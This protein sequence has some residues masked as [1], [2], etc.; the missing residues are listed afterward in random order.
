MRKK[1][2]LLFSLLVSS[3]WGQQLAQTYLVFKEGDS[4]AINRISLEEIPGEKTK[5]VSIVGYVEKPGL[6]FLAVENILI[7][8]LMKIAGTI[9]TN[10]GGRSSS[11]IQIFK[12]G[13]TY[14]VSLDH[15]I[16]IDDE[17]KANVSHLSVTGG[18]VISRSGFLGL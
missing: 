5:F 10:N 13:K 16:R 1:I 4:Y 12:N 17:S 18:E 14:Q 3:I 9:T 2:L 7:E 11:L 8:D 6:Y 15:L